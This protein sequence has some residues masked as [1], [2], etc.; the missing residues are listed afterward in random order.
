MNWE[1]WGDFDSITVD[2]CQ[3]WKL[4]RKEMMGL[5]P[6]FRND[7]NGQMTMIQ[8]RWSS[9]ST[10][11]TSRFITTGTA[12]GQVTTFRLHQGKFRLYWKKNLFFLWQWFS[13]E[14]CQEKLSNIIL[15]DLQKMYI[16]GHASFEVDHLVHSSWSKWDLCI[17]I[18]SMVLFAACW[19]IR[20]MKCW[21]AQ[22]SPFQHNI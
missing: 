22:S 12:R 2:I 1:I 6:N 11:V 14:K 18:H 7:W 4:I 20:G 10:E 16:Q 17:L 19:K 21:K 15:G 3:Q 5:L 8:K 9:S 13:T